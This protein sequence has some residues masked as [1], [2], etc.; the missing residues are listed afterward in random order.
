MFVEDLWEKNPELFKKGLS[1]VLDVD[2]ER[3]VNDKK[4]NGYLRFGI[5]SLY[6]KGYED[7]VIVND[8]KIR[9]MQDKSR[10]EIVDFWVKFMYEIYGDKYAM[11]FISQRNQQLDKFMA[12]YEEKY[13]A[14]TRQMLDVMGF[15]YGK[16]K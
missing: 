10:P 2:K 11:G 13:N 6:G 1:E 8:Y 14:K 16:T 7:G 15:D 12:D 4:G 5:K 9:F 3:L